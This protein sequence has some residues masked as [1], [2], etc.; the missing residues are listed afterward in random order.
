M[1]ILN[2]LND[3]K[4]KSSKKLKAI[5][6]LVLQA[7]TTYGNIDKSIEPIKVQA[8]DGY[9]PISLLTNDEKIAIA[10][11][12]IKQAISIATIAI[13]DT[14]G[15]VFDRVFECYIAVNPILCNLDM[16]S[17]STY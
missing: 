1:K 10:T 12:E 13:E 5:K 2:I 14:E 6:S 17:D 9:I 8:T 4:V 7:R 16:Q 15:T 11:S 3:D